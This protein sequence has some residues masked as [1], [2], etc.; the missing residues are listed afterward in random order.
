MFDD[1]K[2][3][4]VWLC[5]SDKWLCMVNVDTTETGKLIDWLKPAINDAPTLNAVYEPGPM[6]IIIFFKLFI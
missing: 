5:G 6:V 4:P 2:Y 1:S 3:T